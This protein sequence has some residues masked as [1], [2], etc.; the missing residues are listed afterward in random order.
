MKVLD[1]CDQLPF[2]PHSDVVRAESV[3]DFESQRCGKFEVL[4]CETDSDGALADHVD[5]RRYREELEEMRAR[6]LHD[7]EAQRQRIL[8]QLRN[9]ESDGCAQEGQGLTE[10]IVVV[11]K[12]SSSIGSHVS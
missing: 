1:C 4:H 9:Y 3:E 7:A 2:G 5:V 11:G 12:R 8:V 10:M 6:V